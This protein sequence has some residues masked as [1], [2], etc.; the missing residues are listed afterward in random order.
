MAQFRREH[1]VVFLADQEAENAG[2][3]MRKLIIMICTAQ[4]LHNQA[5]QCTHTF[6]NASWNCTSESF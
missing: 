1:W 5:C 3:L 6:L 4:L 2:N